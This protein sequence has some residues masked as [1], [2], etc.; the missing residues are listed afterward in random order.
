[1]TK[2]DAS[3]DFHTVLKKRQNG[4]AFYD[5]F[6]KASVAIGEWQQVSA[7]VSHAGYNYPLDTVYQ[8]TRVANLNTLSSLRAAMRQQLAH[9]LWRDEQDLYTDSL[10]L[11]RSWDIEL[12]ARTGA[13]TLEKLITDILPEGIDFL[14]IP[15]S[16]KAQ[17]A[18]EKYY[19]GVGEILRWTGK[20]L[21]ADYYSGS[22][23]EGISYRLR[24]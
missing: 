18:L 4:R 21:R 16:E 1:M 23:W 7:V 20:I 8:S 17:T 12:P 22:V 10:A 13:L 14:N 15:V 2:I 6:W 19:L 5:T 11:V 3:V 9:I 24:D